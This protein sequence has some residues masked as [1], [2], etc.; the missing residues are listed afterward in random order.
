[1]GISGRVA[2]PRVGLL[3]KQVQLR[4]RVSCWA[5]K[6]KIELRE[7]LQSSDMDDKDL[8]GVFGLAF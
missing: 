3:L 8:T 1:M 5:E 4:E 6:S 7:D 2:F